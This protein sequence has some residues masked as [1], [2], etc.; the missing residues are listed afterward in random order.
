[1]KRT[2]KLSSLMPVSFVGLATLVVLGAAAPHEAIKEDA[3]SKSMRSCVNS[4][5]MDT[6][7]INANTI[8]AEN[9]PREAVVIKVSGCRLNDFDP[10]VFEYAGSSEICAPVD[11]NISQSNMGFRDQCFVESVTAVSPEEV[12]ALKAEAGET[13]RGQAPHRSTL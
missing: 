1:M 13:H 2:N 12:K 11:V 7:V 10:L 5:N 9:G 8:L 3:A 6:Q 4:R